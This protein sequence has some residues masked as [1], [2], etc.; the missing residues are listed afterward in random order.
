MKV[1]AAHTVQAM[2]VIHEEAKNAAR[3]HWYNLVTGVTGSESDE[4]EL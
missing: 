4:K 1:K 2:P 3:F